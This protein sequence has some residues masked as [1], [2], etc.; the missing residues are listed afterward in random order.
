M[1]TVIPNGEDL[2]VS[3]EGGVRRVTL[4][5][6]RAMNALTFTMVVKLYDLLRS[7]ASDPEVKVVLL[8]GAGERGLCAGGDIR[9]LYDA[10]RSGTDLPQQFWKT[11]YHLNALIARFPKPVVAIMDGIVMGG[12]VG[13]SAH[14]SH[15][16]VTE[17]SA[18]AMPEVA[19]GLFPDVGVSFLLSR[20]PGHVGTHLA[21]TGAR[22][23]A[24]D[25]LFCGLADVH[26]VAEK[27]SILREHLSHCTTSRDVTEV[28]NGLAAATRTSDLASARSWIDH[29]YAAN[30]VEDILDRLDHCEEEAA[31]V[32]RQAIQANSPT[33]LKVTLRNLREARSF[34]KIEDCLRQDY[35]I[36]LACIEGHDFIEGIRATVI[37]KDLKPRWCPM[38]I[39]RVTPEIVNQ[40]FRSRGTLDLSFEK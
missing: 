5:R 2:L 1:K 26:V 32:A 31:R 35:R 30:T 28:L 9:A 27:L 34:Q 25:A 3:N 38:D 16:V 14:A 20:T 40:H 7:W 23:G 13:I 21:L 15:R 39:E 4:N 37:D 33:S 29:C 22:I 24:A 12:G 11:E 19:I 10:V 36:A 18:I 8:D 17:R 6:P